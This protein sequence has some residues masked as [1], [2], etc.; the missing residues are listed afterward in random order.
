MTGLM[1]ACLAESAAAERAEHAAQ[2]QAAGGAT[3]AQQAAALV[4]AAMQAGI[5]AAEAQAIVHGMAA[6]GAA[7]AV[8]QQALLEALRAQRAAGGG[9]A[10]AA[11][12]RGGGARSHGRGRGPLRR[13]AAPAY[14]NVP[15]GIPGVPSLRHMVRHRLHRPTRGGRQSNASLPPHLMPPFQAQRTT[16]ADTLPIDLDLN[17][18]LEGLD[19]IDGND[20]WW[21]RLL[22]VAAGA[23]ALYAGARAIKRRQHTFGGV[24]GTVVGVGLIEQGIRGR[25]FATVRS[26]LPP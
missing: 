11:M 23:G 13:G 1:Q 16:N 21:L 7:P 25:A 3:T 26:L 5:P 17:R 22:G 14:E 4:Q 9:G 19:G 6:A 15:S 10:A 8:I 20:P 12:P 24:V 2:A 18:G